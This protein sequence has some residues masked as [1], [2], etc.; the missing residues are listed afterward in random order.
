MKTAAGT[1]A[2]ALPSISR[3]EQLQVLKFVPQAD[4][5]LLDPVQ[6]TAFVTRNHGTM[7]FDT[8]YGLDASYVPQPQMAAGHTIEADGKV[9]NITLRPGLMWHDGTPVL[10][11]DVVASVQRWW[12]IDA[13]GQTLR[14]FTDELTAVSDNGLRFRLKK[15]FPLLPAVFS[16]PSAFFAIMPERLAKTPIATQISE[17]VGSGPFRF[18]PGE[19]VVGS[20]NVYEKFTGYKPRPEGTTSYMAGPKIA[21]LDRVEWHTIPDSSTAAAALQAGEVDWWEAPIPDFVPLLRS[22][23]K[24][25][26]EVKEKAGAL[27]MLRF[28]CLNPPFDNPA[29]R[30]A[31]IGAVEQADYMTSV[32]GSDESLWQS[33]VGFFTPGSSSA[34]DAGMSVLTNPRSVERVKADLKKAGY[35]NERV[36]LLVPA[37]FASLNV[38]SEVT[39]D[40]LRRVGINLDYQTLD[41]GTV[42]QRLMSKEPLDKGG[43][44]AYANYI[45]GIIAISPATHSYIRGVGT[46]APYGWPT[47]AALEQLRDRYL[48]ADSPAMQASICREIQEQAFQDMP[49]LP[50]GLWKQP[51][52]YRT[53]VS[54]I[55]D[56][57]PL[58]YNIKKA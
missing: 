6:A 29:I 10:A 39:G 47:S 31:L 35:N 36:V 22:T 37:D 57:H 12:Q 14:S 18:L 2:L 41:W 46:S 33:N 20:L 13:F 42:T 40:M 48:E 28:N 23:G 45:P 54:G 26:V 7:V 38:M 5:T 9:W 30:R 56:G 58:F 8:L 34:S 21:Y 52:A 11:R 1:A 16:K 51:T 44:S 50:Y 53:S 24:I 19:R 27:G 4:L 49:Y 43:W 17:M 55:P 15:P 32:I 25:N 3:A